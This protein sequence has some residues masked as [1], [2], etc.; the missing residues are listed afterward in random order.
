MLSDIL[1]FSSINAPV[2]DRFTITPSK[3]N[4]LQF[5]MQLASQTILELGTLLFMRYQPLPGTMES[6]HFGITAAEPTYGGYGKTP[7]SCI[8]EIRGLVFL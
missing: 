4:P 3:S 7:Y 6:S 8:L 1:S 2:S 5:R